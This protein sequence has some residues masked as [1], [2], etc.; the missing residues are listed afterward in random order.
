MTR[1]K[2]ISTF[3]PALSDTSILK[4]ALNYA[5]I[6]RFNF[7]H[8]T[9]E[10]KLEAKEKVLKLSK[11]LNKDI[12]LLADLPGPKIRVAKLENDVSIKTGDT[13]IFSH[14]SNVKAGEVPIEID[15]FDDMKV[16]CEIS[17]GDGNPKLIIKDLKDRKIICTALQ[18][19]KIASRKGIN[20]KGVN[21]SAA[22][23]TKEDLNLIEFVRDNGFDYVALSFV[24]NAQNVKEARKLSGNLL[25][26]SKIERQEA[27]TDI[28]EI[29]K[30]SDGIMIARGDMALNIEFNQVPIVQ[31]LII[32]ECRSQGKPVIV[33]TQMLASMT[34]NQ[35]P[36]RAE[37]TD[38]SNAVKSETDCV[39]LSDETAVGKY[40]LDALKAMSSI[41]SYTE[42]VGLANRDREQIKNIN[43]QHEGIALAVVGIT[44]TCKTES[45]FIPTVTGKTAKIL[46]SFRP[47]SEIIA[48]TESE[49]L[50]RSMCMYYGIKG[51]NLGK[52]SNE[53]EL[54]T[55]IKNY[56]EKL[57]I[58]P[59]I[60]VFGKSAK[61]GS[62]D[63][64]KCVW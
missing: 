52:Y 2:I 59:Y 23:P 41:I 57:S 44:K 9:P 22:P 49:V 27:I 17:I 56:A 29:V 31:D 64:I 4:D 26:I 34:S 28:K 15:I 36:T 7:S 20:V 6:I 10:E 25:I 30:E 33:A 13:I 45:I 19:G 54:N 11:E 46:S 62:S 61:N 38:V 16:G 60:I 51:I 18:D 5:D 39:M 40:P 21:M 35:S 50:R 14:I 42:A 58:H 37:M 32:K 8:G 47:D 24:K 48:I 12:A 53:E 43:N 63:T 55:L 1:T 3:G